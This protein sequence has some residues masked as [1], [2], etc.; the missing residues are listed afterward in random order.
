MKTMS[1]YSHLLLLTRYMLVVT[2]ICYFPHFFQSPYWITLLLIGAVSYKFIATYFNFSPLPGWLKLVF[3][4]STVILLKIYYGNMINSGFFIGFLATFIGLKCLEI[5]N[6]R[7]IK[8][9]IICNFYLVLTSLIIDQSLWIVVYLF[10]AILMN[11]LLMLKLNSQQVSFKNLSSRSFKYLLIAI[12]FSLVLFYIFPR[13]AKPLWQVPTHSLNQIGFSE[14]LSPGSITQLFTDDR[15]AFRVTFKDKPILNGYWQGLILNFYNGVSWNPIGIRQSDLRPLKELSTHQNVDYEVMLDPHQ[16]KWLFYLGFPIAANP[17]LLFITNH[18]LV[19]ANQEKIQQRLIYG[20]Q[21]GKELYRPLSATELQQNVQLPANVNNQL[22]SWSRENFINLRNNPE[23]I[24]KNLAVYIRQQPFYYTLMP[25]KLYSKDQMD[26]FWFESRQGYCEHYAS[27]VAIILRAL[28][29]PS[30][31]VVGYQGGI[32]NSVGRYLDIQQNNAHAWI[33]YW[34]ENLG[35]QRVDP[36][37]FIA[38]ERIDKAIRNLQFSRLAQQRNDYSTSLSWLQ[39]SQF[40]METLRFFA[41]RWLLFYNQDTQL[42]L[43][44]KL[45]LGHWNTTDLLR[46]AIAT[47]LCFIIIMGLIYA[48]SQYRRRDPLAKAYQQLQR[49]FKRFNIPINPAM[50]LQKQCKILQN[51]LPHLTKEILEFLLSY[52]QIRLQFIESY[53]KNNQK[54]TVLLFKKLRKIL[55]K[56]PK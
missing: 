9:L 43:L 22:I 56:N 28:G 52:D 49:E 18:G 23:Q 11:V 5:H 47:F 26:E 25:N 46:A 44:K 15:T 39:R 54:E 13:I 8:F 14:K 32:W 3:I 53:S 42:D 21:V 37:S 1:K 29:I 19:L 7:D 33:E 10:I 24:I 38:P 4:I 31:V 12:P 45:G 36:T 55:I 27:A 16:K 20:I 35:W 50:T 30:R 2:L 48:L 6:I 41:D 40:F 51:K 17:K 34:Q